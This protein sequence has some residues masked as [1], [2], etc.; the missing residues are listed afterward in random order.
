[1]KQ[2]QIKQKHQTLQI[3]I[4][5]GDS[6]DVAPVPNNLRMFGHNVQG[7]PATDE[8]I[9]AEEIGNVATHHFVDVLG[10]NEP[11][12]N[13]HNPKTKRKFTQKLRAFWPQ[14]VVESASAIASTPTD[15]YHPGGSV[16]ALGGHWVGRKREQTADPSGLGRW[17]SITLQGKG[18]KMLTI[19]TAYCPVK[20]KIGRSGVNTIF[21]QQWTALRIAGDEHPEVR[22]SFYTDLT[23][24]IQA[25]KDPNH[26]VVVMI[27]ANGHPDDKDSEIPKFLQDNDLGDV[28]AYVHPEM[29]TPATWD[30]G[31][32]QIDFMFASLSILPFITA[33]GFLAFGDATK[34]DHR[35]MFCDL[36][37]MR[38]LGDTP[39]HLI[40]PVQ[41]ML[42]SNNPQSVAKYKEHLAQYFD[43][44]NIDDRVRQ[45][46]HVPIA[47]LQ[48]HLRRLDND[49]TR[50][51]LY[52]ERQCT[53]RHNLPWSP[54]LKQAK[55]NHTYWVLW[56]AEKR[57]QKDYSGQRRATVESNPMIK[58]SEEKPT[59]ATIKTQLKRRG[60]NY[61]QCK[62]THKKEEQNFWKYERKQRRY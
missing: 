52:A 14:M 40:S 41:R 60:N 56:L 23:E 43:S 51:M 36:D 47:R 21:T 12:L 34:S 20:D 9:A 15:N 42:H 4:P 46:D 3:N 19:I 62:A 50:G 58:T 61:K 55:A 49:I 10:L 1:M 38:T 33:A 7:V 54:K 13:F 5:C 26:K 2:T 48:A 6:I 53:N 57:L 29:E 25:R 37:M 31:R 18:E 30:R 17:T 45:I 39:A 44:H 59:I 16:T 11:N 27:D 28:H 22:Q 35:G 8:F 32:K 24:F